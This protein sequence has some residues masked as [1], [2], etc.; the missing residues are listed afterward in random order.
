MEVLLQTQ[1]VLVNSSLEIEAKVVTLQISRMVRVWYAKRINRFH[2][3]FKLKIYKIIYYVYL[4]NK[5]W[6]ITHDSVINKLLEI[7]ETPFF[8]RNGRK[9][10]VFRNDMV[11]FVCYVLDVQDG[12]SCS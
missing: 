8:H 6:I 3:L 1:V 4:Y 11:G 7:K 12:G 2:V 10:L 9:S 5:F